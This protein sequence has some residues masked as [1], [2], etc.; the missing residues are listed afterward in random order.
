MYI[1]I[2]R[3]QRF[4]FTQSCSNMRLNHMK[5]NGQSQITC[6]SQQLS[7]IQN[8]SPPAKNN[9]VVNLVKHHHH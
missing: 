3:P 6:K 9:P 5:R 8:I 4:M 7:R 1:Y 2:M